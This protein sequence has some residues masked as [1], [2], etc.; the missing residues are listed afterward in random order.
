MPEHARIAVV[1]PTG[2]TGG[3]LLRILTGHP[4]VEVRALLRTGS[5]ETVSLPQAH[6]HLRGVLHLDCVPYDESFL[7]GV[8][9]AFLAVPSGAA[10]E[11]VPTLLDRG[12]KVIDLSADF[13]F[14][15]PAVYSRVYRREHKATALLERAT[16]GLPELY[17]WRIRE[18]YLV[19]NPGCYPISVLIALLPLA[20]RG[21]IRPEIVVDSKSGISG[22]GRNRLE[23]GYLFTEL[24]GDFRPY[25]VGQ[26][27]HAPE[28]IQELRQLLGE[29]PALSF[30]PHLIPI[31][32]GILSTIYCSLKEPVPLQQVRR[33]YEE[34]YQGEPFVRIVPDGELPRVKAVAGS[35]FCDLAFAID[36]Y[37]G[38]LIILSSLDN[39]TKGAAGN[40][41]QCLNLMM[42]WEETTGLME[43]GLMP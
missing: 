41:V 23:V 4:M 13:R 31:S 28:M 25:S 34:D 39:L 37:S 10:M 20:K 11:L 27:R 9:A 15:D 42:G 24:F 17:R 2:Y 30:T 6:P 38:H 26:H 5:E 29:E 14:R 32:R 19:A 3:E 36:R 22:A 21:L 43:P 33:L 16:Y 35:N 18:S 40:A 8:D 1:G 12:I 7:D